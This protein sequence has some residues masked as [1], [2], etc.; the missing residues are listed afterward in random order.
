MVVVVAVV[1]VDVAIVEIDVPRVVGMTSA[2]HTLGN[3][4]AQ[5]CG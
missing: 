5:P 4:A 3:F 1:V 2:E